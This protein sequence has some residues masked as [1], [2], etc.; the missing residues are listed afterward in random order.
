MKETTTFMTNI[1]YVVLCYV[2]VLHMIY[3]LHPNCNNLLVAEQNLIRY[4]WMSPRFCFVAPVAMVNTFR[5]YTSES[6]LRYQ[7]QAPPPYI[8]Y[9]SPPPPPHY[10]P[11]RLVH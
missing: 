9:P 4:S 10:T 5:P 3:S 2:A 11:Y 7:I 1:S 6:A 8:V